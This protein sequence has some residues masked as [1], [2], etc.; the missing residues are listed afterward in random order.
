MLGEIK[1]SFEF[2]ISKEYLT[3][4]LESQETEPGAYNAYVK[5]MNAELIRRSLALEP[6]PKGARE[7]YRHSCAY[8]LPESK[9]YVTGFLEKMCVQP[10]NRSPWIAL[11]LY[12]ALLPMGDLTAEF[13]R[14]LYEYFLEAIKED[15]Y[16]RTSILDKYSELTLLFQAYQAVARMH[17]YDLNTTEF[18]DTHREAEKRVFGV[19]SRKLWVGVPKDYTVRRL[20]NVQ[21]GHIYDKEAF[22]AV[23][24]K[25]VLKYLKEEK[26]EYY[27]EDLLCSQAL[28][29]GLSAETRVEVESINVYRNL[30]RLTGEALSG[31]EISAHERDYF[32]KMDAVR[33]VRITAGMRYSVDELIADYYVNVK[34]QLNSELKMARDPSR[35]IG[36]PSEWVTAESPGAKVAKKAFEAAIHFPLST[37]EK[38]DFYMHVSRAGFDIPLEMRLKYLTL[39]KIA[40]SDDFPKFLY[41]FCNV[42]QGELK[43]LKQSEVVKCVSGL[44][45]DKDS[46]EKAK[47]IHDALQGGTRLNEFVSLKS[48]GGMFSTSPETLLKRLQAE[49]DKMEVRAKQRIVDSHRDLQLQAVKG[50][51]SDMKEGAHRFPS[52]L[53][54]MVGSQFATGITTTKEFDVYVCQI[55]FGKEKISPVIAKRLM[56]AEA[57]GAGS[58][59]SI[60]AGLSPRFLLMRKIA[61]WLDQNSRLF[62]TIS[63][64]VRRAA[65]QAMVDKGDIEGLL[66]QDSRLNDPTICLDFKEAATLQIEIFRFIQPRGKPEIGL[67]RYVEIEKSFWLKPFL[68]VKE[69]RVG[70]DKVKSSLSKSIEENR[71]DL[72][73]AV[74][75]QRGG[76][77]SAIFNAENRML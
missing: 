8:N 7:F 62:Q 35:L 14:P 36:L 72:G 25:V 40:L 58:T 68:A 3:K 42:I 41:L 57:K 16:K 12:Q 44:I 46:I 13:H 23:K 66:K 26:P 69:F 30:Y 2:D 77:N 15:R 20:L 65:L 73:R 19:L 48:D 55:M 5:K 51:Q 24:N 32:E 45:S 31:V 74:A 49:W 27:D 71:S 21:N 64:T 39:K 10:R 9:S 38:W 11:K 28:R 6:S 18:I 59:V 22:K 67:K 52:V 37:V 61:P 63:P 54:Q 17:E 50:I 33:F 60:S 1:D 56:P 70:L 53:L 76:D 75:S 43:G 47:A 29:W 4:L 34:D